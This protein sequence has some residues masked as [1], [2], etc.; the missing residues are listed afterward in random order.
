MRYLPSNV[1]FTGVGLALM[2]VA[3]SCSVVTLARGSYAGPLLTAITCAALALICLAVPFI[4]GPWPWRIAALVFAAP[5][6]YVAAEFVR[7]APRAFDGL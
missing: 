2:A 7:R 1:L 6:L 5:A 3:S 4:R